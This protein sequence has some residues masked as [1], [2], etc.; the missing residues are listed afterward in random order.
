MGSRFGRFEDRRFRKSSPENAT[1]PLDSGR[2]DT[3]E[4]QIGH[5]AVQAVPRAISRALSCRRRGIQGREP[6]PAASPPPP[7]IQAVPR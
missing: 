1:F 7:P 4:V 5:R 6:P 3:G 2:L